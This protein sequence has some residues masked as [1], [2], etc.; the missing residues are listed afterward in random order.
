M[1]AAI[2]GSVMLVCGISSCA[3]LE[4]PAPVVP[5]RTQQA[6][7]ETPPAD[8]E[9]G[10]ADGQ[11]GAFSEALNAFAAGEQPVAGREIVDAVV[12]AGFNKA[13]M[14]VSFDTS[15]TNLIAD[16]LYVSVQIGDQCLLGQVV[17]ESRAVVTDIAPAIG[18]E[19][20]ICLI[21][22]TRPIDW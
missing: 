6:V 13:M 18:P 3:L 11:L 2:A 14:Q 16:S 21:G 9:P 10:S 8:V 20:N 17:T 4:G 15:R 19:Q 22:D 1:T 7:P 5:E 12:G